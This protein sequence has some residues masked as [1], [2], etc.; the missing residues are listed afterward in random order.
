[1]AQQIAA[2]GHFARLGLAVKLYKHAGAR[3]REEPETDI[4][5]E[6]T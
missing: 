2:D 5:K 6:V 3:Q 4:I 1:M